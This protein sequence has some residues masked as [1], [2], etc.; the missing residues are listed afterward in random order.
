VTAKTVVLR[1]RRCVGSRELATTPLVT[2]AVVIPLG[3]LLLPLSLPRLRP[4]GTFH[5]SVLG[6]LLGRHARIISPTPVGGRAA[7]A[8]R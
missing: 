7:A 2:G 6:R 1:A 5:F 3:R 4:L 8:C